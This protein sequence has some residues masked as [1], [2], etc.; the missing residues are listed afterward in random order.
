MKKQMSTAGSTPSMDIYSLDVNQGSRGLQL[1]PLMAAIEAGDSNKVKFFLENGA[2][3]NIQNTNGKTA[4]DLAE[5]NPIHPYWVSRSEK[6]KINS[7][8]NQY[9]DNDYIEQSKYT[10][11]NTL[12][13]HISHQ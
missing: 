13:E 7:L 12:S 10:E 9:K 4:F 5:H 8:L 6:A 2:N 1:T 3:P 11:R